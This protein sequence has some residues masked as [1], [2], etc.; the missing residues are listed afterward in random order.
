MPWEQEF[1]MKNSNSETSSSF[2]TAV[3]GG[4]TDV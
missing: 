3:F 2:F 4:K 1:D